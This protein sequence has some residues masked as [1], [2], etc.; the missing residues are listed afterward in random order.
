MW[1][2]KSKTVPQASD[3]ALRAVESGH[4]QLEAARELHVQARQIRTAAVRAHTTN[5]FGQAV[6]AAMGGPIHRA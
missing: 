6:T 3:E 4:K 5:H 2:W 1:P